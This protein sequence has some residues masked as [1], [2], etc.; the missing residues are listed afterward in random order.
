MLIAVRRHFAALICLM[1]QPSVARRPK[2]DGSR[3]PSPVLDRGREIGFRC[4][5]AH[6]RVVDFQRRAR[7]VGAFVGLQSAQWAM[8][9]LSALMNYPSYQASRRLSRVS[10]SRCAARWVLVAR[11]SSRRGTP[12]LVAEG[13]SRPEYGNGR[14]SRCIIAMPS[15]VSTARQA[16]HDISIPISAGR[17]KPIAPRAAT[18][19]SRPVSSRV[20]QRRTTAVPN[21]SE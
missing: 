17:A 11:L 18:S 8:L 3:Q 21:S 2:R 15:P 1:S 6:S 5:A 13:A 16:E 10:R 12:S 4:N 9:V 7:I 20:R 14:D 19:S